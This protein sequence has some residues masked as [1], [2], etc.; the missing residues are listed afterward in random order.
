MAGCSTSE[1]SR[2]ETSL[3]YCVLNRTLEPDS[4]SR[5]K[6]Q[7]SRDGDIYSHRLREGRT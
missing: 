6:H 2:G 7:D 1:E 4:S 3:L 5:D